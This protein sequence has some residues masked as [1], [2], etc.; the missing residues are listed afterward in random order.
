ME[1]ALEEIQFLANSANRVRVL[2]TLTDEP[3]TRRELQEEAGV[4]RSTA[5]R[6]LD[7]AEARGWVDSAGSRYT[8]TPLGEAGVAAFRTYV[9]T[10]KGM[11]H[12]GEAIDW[13]PEPVH[14]LGFRHFRDATI[15]T[16]TDGNPTAPFDRGLEL[17]RAADEYRG[18]TR[19]SLSPNT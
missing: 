8:I 5:G 17:I 16:P 1:R 13:L 2:E 3:A 7:E 9:E 12:L 11:Q 14:A 18:L 10:T 4:P 19:N 15:T 6:V